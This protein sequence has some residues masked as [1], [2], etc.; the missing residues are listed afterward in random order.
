MRRVVNLTC[1]VIAAMTLAPR[2]STQ[3]SK[4]PPAWLGPKPSAPPRSPRRPSRSLLLV[5][6]P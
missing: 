6:P 1:S 2:P 4:W 3:G 5:A